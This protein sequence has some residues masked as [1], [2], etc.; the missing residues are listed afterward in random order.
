MSAGGNTISRPAS[1]V[2]HSVPSGGKY[3]QSSSTSK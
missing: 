1:S 2:V 3:G